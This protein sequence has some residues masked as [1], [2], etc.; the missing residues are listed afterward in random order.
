[1][2]AAGELELKQFSG[3]DV[4]S[5]MRSLSIAF[6]VLLCASVCCQVRPVYSSVESYAAGAKLICVGKIAKIEDVVIKSP[7]MISHSYKAIELTIEVSETLKGQQQKTIKAHRY[8]K[9]DKQT[10]EAI[11]K[12][13]ADFVWFVPGG[14][15]TAGFPKDTARTEFCLEPDLSEYKPLAG[16]AIGMDFTML[17]SR[18]DLLARIRNF[19]KENPAAKAG[20]ALLTPLPGQSLTGWV[21]FLVPLGP[22]TEKLAVRMITKPD[23]FTFGP[24]VGNPYDPASAPEWRKS[25]AGMLRTEGLILL[26]HFKSDLNIGLVTR[27]LNDSSIVMKQKYGKP[28]TT[29][30]W[31]RDAAY[32]LLRLWKVKVDQP[33]VDGPIVEYRNG[34]FMTDGSRLE[35]M[36]RDH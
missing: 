17:R 21:D 3:R 27:H 34:L 18:Q 25:K 10:Y 2:S 12:A 15:S 30:Y 22:W 14:E 24:P 26:Q 11:R 1:M 4:L 8:G 31:V 36:F 35:Y 13:G 29:Y 9:D 16:L 33:L 23:S 5:F 20:V 19:L 32:R 7:D 6:T 28:I